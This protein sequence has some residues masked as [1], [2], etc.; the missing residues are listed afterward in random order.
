MNY[1]R[2]ITMN[3]K[4]ISTKIKSLRTNYDLFNVFFADIYKFNQDDDYLFFNKTAT[5]LYPS[6]VKLNIE[7]YPDST[8]LKSLHKDVEEFVKDHNAFDSLR[9]RIKMVD[10]DYKAL[11]KKVNKLFKKLKLSEKIN[12]KNASYI[13]FTTDF[14]ADDEKKYAI[15]TDYINYYMYRRNGDIISIIMGVLDEKGK[16]STTAFVYRYKDYKFTKIADKKA[17]ELINDMLD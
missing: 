5:V 15:E 11:D 17:I 9:R 7:L 12:T 3:L 2:R 6:G 8:D 10:M 16:V 4:E 14:Y 13:V 1:K